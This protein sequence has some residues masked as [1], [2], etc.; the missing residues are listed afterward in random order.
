M[1]PETPPGMKEAVVVTGHSLLQ[2]SF[3]DRHVESA[4]VTEDL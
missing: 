3:F 2:R 1:A 4:S